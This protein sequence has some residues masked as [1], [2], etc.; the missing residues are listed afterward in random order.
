MCHRANRSVVSV[1]IKKKE[2]DTNFQ[3]EQRAL[4]WF[5]FVR[6]KVSRRFYCHKLLFGACA[7]ICRLLSEKTVDLHRCLGTHASIILRT[8]DVVLLQL[9]SI[10]PRYS[11]NYALFGL[12]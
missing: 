12:D 11:N 10:R 3:L 7:R 5:Q 8:R 1:F 4:A 6:L 2:N 9:L